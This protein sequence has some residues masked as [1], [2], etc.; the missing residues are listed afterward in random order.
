MFVDWPRRLAYFACLLL[1]VLALA[2]RGNAETPRPLI[3]PPSASPTPLAPSLP[4]PPIIPEQPQ[5]VPVAPLIEK[6]PAADDAPNAT[7]D[8]KYILDDTRGERLFTNVCS[9]RLKPFTETLRSGHTSSDALFSYFDKANKAD[10]EILRALVT[11]CANGRFVLG[12]LNEKLECV[13]YYDLERRHVEVI[14]RLMIIRPETADL[15][16]IG[17]VNT[18]ETLKFWTLRATG[19]LIDHSN[20]QRV[21]ISGAQISYGVTIGGGTKIPGG[22]SIDS[23]SLGRILEVTGDSEIGTASKPDDPKDKTANTTQFDIS[24]TVIDGTVVFRNAKF[25]SNV[26]APGNRIEGVFEILNSTFE[27]QL[28]LRNASIGGHLLMED[29][30]V[31]GETRLTSTHL[32]SLYIT[33]GTFK[34]NVN[35][36]LIRA[37]GTT[38]IMDSKFDGGLSLSQL[39]S[40]VVSIGRSEFGTEQK[41]DD[42]TLY[43]TSTAAGS[44]TISNSTVRNVFFAGNS[45]V[46][47]FDITT[48][49]VPRFDCTDCIIEQYLLLGGEFSK[50]VRLWGSHIKSQL[51]LRER[52]ICAR[53]TKDAILDLRG[54]QT[55]SIAA[56]YDDLMVFDVPPP[57]DQEK[58]QRC[59]RKTVRTLI[60][61]ASFEQI[62]PGLRSLNEPDLPTDNPHRKAC[63][64]SANQTSILDHT[65]DDVLCWIEHGLGTSDNKQVYDPRPYQLVASALETAGRNDSAVDVRIAKVDA[66]DLAA[67]KDFFYYLKVPFKGLS[68]LISGYGY[69]NEWAIGWFLGLVAIGVVVFVFGRLPHANVLSHMPKTDAFALGWYAFWFSVD[70]AVPPLVLDTSMNE[71]S[72]L[73]PWARGYYYLHRALGTIII[74]VAIASLTGVFK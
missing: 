57:T 16:A 53:W 58:K 71:Y 14:R 4:T 68:Y 20:I 34:K 41:P 64:T 18:K 42:G 48:T 13:E 2:Q 3:P 8:A 55:Q 22:L 33:R 40:G 30:T 26:T 51:R 17:C 19:I 44:V 63:A 6:A 27:N 39:S 9:E 54:L 45:R 74:T 52:N 46:G 12:Q 10:R 23:S 32:K 5:A 70:R 7:D 67:R 31:G 21:E 43:M 60:S 62:I 69:H 25:H 37:T 47:S 59:A 72:I 38:S 15:V 35:A 66:E 49:K 29:V 24:R 36:E 1:V 56:D 28:N 61:G 65:S 73:K 11:Y 50:E